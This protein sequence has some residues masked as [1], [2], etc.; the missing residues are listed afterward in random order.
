[1]SVKMKPLRRVLMIFSNSYD[2]AYPRD[3]AHGFFDAGIE[4]GFISLSKAAVPQ[5]INNHSAKE[6]SASFGADI[7][8]ARKVLRTISVIREFKPDIIQAHLFLGGIVGLIAGKIMGIPVI[9]TRHH[10]DEHYQSGT[11]V[12]RWIDRVV[13]KRS[14]HVVVC[15]TAAERWLIDV[16]GVKE[17]HVTVINQGF[18]FSYLSP[19]VEA[20][21]KAKLDLGFSE[22]RL[23]IV[24]VARYSKAKGQNYLLL[25]LAEL[26]KTIPNISLT[27]MGPGES[28]WLVK[29]VGE[30]GLEQNVLI[31][32]SRDDV[33]A[34]I[35][36]ADMTIHPSLADSF[37][38]LVIEAQAVGGL[39]ISSDIAAVR[40][41]II[42]GVTGVIVRPRD[43]Q[44][45]ANTV[46]YLVNN[47]DIAL[48]MRK[49]GPL[50]VREKF[51][52]Q[53]MVDEEIT[54]LSRY[55]V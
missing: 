29:L 17:K 28:Q 48:S 20:I 7:S 40:E 2:G 22:E 18:D 45:I 44:A 52:W 6:F 5:W 43:S 32:P 15:S 53:R 1:M 10:I 30:L 51:T 3:L 25:A 33:P 26:V 9:H 41:Q 46:L 50:H 19:S 11:F 31:L 21:E 35:A 49:N 36:A 27:L 38:Q 12:H 34:C 16:E 54:C 39:L 14:N 37:S 4:I 24:C 42:D 55:V 13:A 23:N 47:P 8:L